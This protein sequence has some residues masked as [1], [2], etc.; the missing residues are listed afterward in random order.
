MVFVVCTMERDSAILWCTPWKG[1]LQL[2]GVTT[3][4]V[5]NSLLQVCV[6]DASDNEDVEEKESSDGEKEKAEETIELSVIN[7]PIH[8]VND[9]DDK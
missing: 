1:I 9:D 2:R 4:A 8:D 5:P 6:D 3:M 7:L